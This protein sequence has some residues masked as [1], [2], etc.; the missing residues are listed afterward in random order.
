MGDFVPCREIDYAGLRKAEDRLK[1]SDCSLGCGAEDTD[2]VYPGNGGVN[3][4]DGVQLLLNLPDFVAS[5]ADCQVIA[6]PGC[7]DSG[8]FICVVYIDTV[9]V[10]VAENLYRTVSFFAQSHRTPLGQPNG[11]GYKEK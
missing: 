6:W 9:A 10:E 1:F 7:R 4:G 5:G 2:R 3:C 8:D 11:R